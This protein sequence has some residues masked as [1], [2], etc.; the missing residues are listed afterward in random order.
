M[1]HNLVQKHVSV[2]TAT[3]Y[4]QLIVPTT[5][6]ERR[7]KSEFGNFINTDPHDGE[8]LDI[9]VTM[10]S[11]SLETDWRK[12]TLCAEF[13]AKYMLNT[14]DARRCHND[15]ESRD[16]KDAINYI[17]NELFENA[18][19]FTDEDGCRE[20]SFRVENVGEKV[21]F[22]VRNSI[23]EAE[24]STFQTLIRELLA[25]DPADMYFERIEAN[26]ASECNSTSGLG[27]LSIMND[28]DADIA[29]KFETTETETTPTYVTTMIQINV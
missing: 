5:M 23:D 14:I 16:I 7:L 17:A 20:I 25:G 15:A 3:K 2:Y 6:E 18:V 22:Y 27:Y 9:V 13:I 28:Y 29:W 12:N 10:S 1:N 21:R 11:G 19:K 26:E 4:G 8:Y 24:I